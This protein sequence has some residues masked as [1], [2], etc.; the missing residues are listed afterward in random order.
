ML[1]EGAERLAVYCKKRT[2]DKLRS[3]TVYRPEGTTRVYSD[4]MLRERYTEEQIST[5]VQSAIEL[6]TTLHHSNV[7]DAPLGRPIAGVYSF[8]EAFVIQL[9]W[10]E[11]SGIVATFDVDIGTS[12]AG[13]IN[14]CHDIVQGESPSTEEENT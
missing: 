5:L 10:D 1:E 6:N 7:S 3:V 14:D 4:D 8:E 2:G 9:P 12:L 13:F 11:T